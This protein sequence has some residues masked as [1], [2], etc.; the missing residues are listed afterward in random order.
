M[1]AQRYRDLARPSVVDTG[2]SQ[3]NAGSTADALARTFSNFQSDLNQAGGQLRSQQG[4]VEGE[5]AGASEHFGEHDTTTDAN[6]KVT[7]GGLKVDPATG[8]PYKGFRNSLS[9]V[10]AY[11]QAYNNSATR[12]YAVKLDADTDEADARIREQSGSDPDK[13]KALMSASMQGLLKEADPRAVGIIR[14]SYTRRIGNGVAAL[15]AQRAKEVRDANRVATSEG[16]TQA[17]ER[18]GRLRS[19]GDHAGAEIEKAKLDGLFQASEADGTF[20]PAELAKLKRQADI[21]MLAQEEQSTFAAELQKPDGDPRA[22]IERLKKDYASSEVLH[23]DEEDHVIDTL[24]SDWRQHNAM[25]TARTAQ[26]VGEHTDLVMGVFERRGQEAGASMLAGLP[27]VPEG[28]KDAVRNKVLQALNDRRSVAREAHVDELVQIARSEAQG[29]VSDDDYVTTER[30]YDKGA[31]SPEEYAS[32]LAGLDSSRIKKSGDVAVAAAV[33]RSLETGVPLDPSDKKVKEALASAFAVQTAGLEEGSPEWR[34]TTLAFA[35][36]T[37]MLPNQAISWAEKMRR[38]PDPTQ[39]VPAAQLLAS[40]HELAPQALEGIDEK[41]RAFSSLVNDAAGSGADPEKAV[42]MARR[43]VYETDKNV[44]ETLKAQYKAGKFADSSNSALDSY[45]DSDFDTEVFGQPVAPMELQAAFRAQTERYYDITRGDISKARELAWKDLKSISGVSEVNGHKQVMIAP[46][47][48]FGVSPEQ[49][50]TDISELIKA[51]P[52]P[53]GSTADDV[54]IVPDSTTQ[55]SVFDIASGKLARPSYVAYGKSGFPLV[56]AN[57]KPQRYNLPDSSAIAETFAKKR[58]EAEARES[59]DMQRVRSYRD[60]RR[61][62]I[63]ARRN[64]E[65]G[66]ALESAFGE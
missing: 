50:R 4:E 10:T 22:F 60:A 2:I 59:A 29:T 54:V 51:V 9:A 1:P 26:A 14:E 35:A 40:L 62:D 52:Q 19:E 37:R 3:G 56:D 32:K 63:D 17:V 49:V 15:T 45:I 30:L 53:D 20:T 28:L 47:E 7:H 44:A 41:S 39:V 23:Q 57:G 25:E 27:G 24:F 5:A 38:S 48:D 34:A 65:H 13:Y 61:K 12:S 21:G 58:A 31:L 8:K 18:I 33:Q 36:R 16:A 64:G 42:E 11:G 55:R 43:T 66:T 6:G 46:P